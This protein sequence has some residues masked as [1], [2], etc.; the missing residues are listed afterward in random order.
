MKLSPIKSIFA[1]LLLLVNTL[2]ASCALAKIPDIIALVNNQPITKYEFAARRQLAVKLNNIDVAEGDI[3]RQLNNSITKMLIDEEIIMQHAKKVGGKVS[4]AEVA[5]AIATLEQ[6]N[7]MPS[8]E[9]IKTLKA[10]GV[11]IES[12]KKQIRAEI[13]K[14]NVLSSL[15]GSVMISEKELDDAVET[16]TKD[17]VMVEMWQF[18]ADEKN[19]RRLEQIQKQIKNCK[20]AQSV[21]K[22]ENINASYFKEQSVKSFDSKLRALIAETKVGTSSNIYKDDGQLKFFFLCSKEL[23]EKLEQDPREQ[24]KMLLSNKKL[25]KRAEKF[26][27]D[28]KNRAVIEIYWPADLAK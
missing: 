3:N 6:Q 2:S 18:A 27:R 25:S 10:K 21:S 15:S 9:L 8:G 5:A 14:Q 7:K 19:K 12:F 26:F 24:F 1:I 13:V 28:V 4:E 17:L 11:S 20:N 22:D 16:A 23:Q